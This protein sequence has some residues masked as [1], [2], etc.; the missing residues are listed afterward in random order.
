MA[1]HSGW[2]LQCEKCGKRHAQKC[3]IGTIRCF[4][5]GK[6]DIIFEIALERMY[7]ILKF[8]PS[9]SC[10]TL[11]N[12]SMSKQVALLTNQ[13]YYLMLKVNFR[14]FRI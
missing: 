3:L 7:L 4:R 6:E 14:I 12:P 13:K 10:E 2:L 11:I 8:S 9:H 1:S 5:C